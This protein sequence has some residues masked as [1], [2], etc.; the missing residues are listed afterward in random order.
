MKLFRLANTINSTSAPYNQFSLGLKETIDQTFCSLLQHDVV[1]DKDIKG[2]HGDGSILKMLK[3]VKG[4]VNKNKYDVVH[5]H[6]G[7]TGIIFILAVF[8]FRLALLKNTVFTLHNSWNVL[9]PRNQLLD[10]IVMLASRKVC[11]CGVSSRDSIPKIINYF[12]GKKTKAIVNGFDHQRIDSVE[13]KRLDN[14]NFDKSS[15]VKI[16]YV[17]ALNN[18]KNQIALLE[19]LKTTKMEAEVIFLGDGVNKKTLIDYSKHI[20]DSVKVAFKGRV[21]RDLAIE[22]MLEADVSISLSKGEGLPIAVLESMYVGCFM[23]LSIIPPHKEVSPPLER[24][25]FVDISNKVEIINSLN[26]VRNNIKQI[27]ASRAKSKEYSISNFS[28]NNMLGEYKKVYNSL[29]EGNNQY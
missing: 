26:Y 3:L 21:S 25:F 5:I 20:P 2:F 13:N 15:K 27:R 10:F 7:V 28:V 19:V 8:P 18:T 11:I 14:S 24:C 4:L 22:H 6:N 17:G 16:V 1:I 23:I 29:Y 12:V 9:N